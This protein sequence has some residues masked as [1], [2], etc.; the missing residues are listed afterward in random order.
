[1]FPI[2]SLSSSVHALS[3]EP[4]CWLSSSSSFI[5]SM[6]LYP[7]IL[8]PFHR[9]QFLSNLAQ[10]SPLYL[11]SDYP[12]SFLAMNHSGNS[13]LLNIPSSFSCF[14]MSSI[15]CQYSFSY[16]SIASLAF[17]KF[18]LSSQVSDS[19]VNPFHHTRYL[20]FPHILCLFRILSTSYLLW[21][22]QVGK[23]FPCIWTLNLK[24]P[25]T[26]WSKDINRIGT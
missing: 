15:S 21:E 8:P 20:S 26:Q 9:L 3:P 19:A 24:S 13:P 22:P 12:N 18:S 6:V 10:Y 23:G 5:V 2:S 7:L 16:S 11:L 25:S 4:P 1:M 17:S 14:L